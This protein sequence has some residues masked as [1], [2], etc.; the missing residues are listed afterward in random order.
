MKIPGEKKKCEAQPG[1]EVKNQA[2][3][4]KE[5]TLNVE[6]AGRAFLLAVGPKYP[7][8]LFC[9]EYSRNVVGIRWHFGPK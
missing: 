4:I 3:L 6:D 7:L 1:T 2:D 8:G 5:S 9:M